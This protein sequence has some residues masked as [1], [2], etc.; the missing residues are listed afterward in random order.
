MV[1]IAKFGD[2]IMGLVG[3]TTIEIL[4]TLEGQ[5]PQIRD[6]PSEIGTVGNYAKNQL[7]NFGK[8]APTPCRAHWYLNKCTFKVQIM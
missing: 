1:K 7:P 4:K 5:A 8:L 6:C 2:K 3:G